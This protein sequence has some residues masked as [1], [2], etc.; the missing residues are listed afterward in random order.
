MAG[1]GIL[2]SAA[3][4]VGVGMTLAACGA[5]ASD[6]SS[7]RYGAQT[8]SATP[9]IAGKITKPDQTPSTVVLR[10]R[11]KNGVAVPKVVVHLD[12]ITPCDPARQ[13]F[14]AGP[15]ESLGLVATTDANGAATYLVVVGCYHFG[16]KTAPAGQLPVSTDDSALFVTTPGQTVEGVLTFLDQ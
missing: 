2:S 3:A 7:G 10:A 6:T 4:L 14:P 11:T 9:S 5:P 1:R 8:V 16:V 12:L 15:V 13:N